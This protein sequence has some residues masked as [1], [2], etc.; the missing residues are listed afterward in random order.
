MVKNTRGMKISSVRQ[1]GEEES[2][3]AFIIGSS[4]CLFSL[5]R[6]MQIQ[7]LCDELFL[8]MLKK[9]NYTQPFMDNVFF[10]RHCEEGMLSTSALLLSDVDGVL[11][12]YAA[13]R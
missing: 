3:S 12:L 4:R 5:C 13:C 1:A 7:Q 11:S 8:P 10:M 9:E 6:R 2:S